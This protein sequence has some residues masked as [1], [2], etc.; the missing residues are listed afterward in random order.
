MGLVRS[1]WLAMCCGVASWS[2]AGTQHIEIYEYKGSAWPPR[3][4]ESVV[5]WKD[6]CVAIDES[7]CTD[8]VRGIATEVY[9]AHRHL[10]EPVGDRGEDGSGT[11]RVFIHGNANEQNVYDPSGAIY[12]H[13]SVA[14]G[15]TR[16][17]PRRR[18]IYHEMGH[19]AFDKHIGTR[20][21][22]HSCTPE[23]VQHWGVDEGLALI[24]ESLADE[25]ADTPPAAR[26]PADE[27]ADAPPA[28]SARAPTPVI[29]LEAQGDAP[30]PEGTP[31]KEAGPAPCGGCLSGNAALDVVETLLRRLEVS[32]LG[33]RAE[34]VA[35]MSWLTADRRHPPPPV[36]L[37]DAP[38]DYKYGPSLPMWV[39]AQADE[40]WVVWYQTAW[41]S[42]DALESRIHAGMLPPAARSWGP[43]K[44]ERYVL[45]NAR[46][47]DVDETAVMPLYVGLDESRTELAWQAAGTRAR[48]W[49]EAA[50]QDPAPN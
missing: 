30:A 22:R 34:L 41:M 9:E 2:T 17:R 5:L 16:D 40:I 31:A 10:K 25:V 4:V 49:L 50:T 46:T 43:L 33:I 27:A 29:G 24:T 37:A 7:M 48:H 44:G 15:G 39:D 36:G 47:G 23:L 13:S 20:T 11:I 21:C 45:V 18:T 26:P 14:R 42:R 6:G 12:L 35:E 32:Y 19:A 3:W 28:T 38:H 1:A 8:S